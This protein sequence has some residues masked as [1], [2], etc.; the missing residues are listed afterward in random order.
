MWDVDDAVS[1]GACSDSPP[2]HVNCTEQHVHNSASAAAAASCWLPSNGESR[3]AHYVRSKFANEKTAS[4]KRVVCHNTCSEASDA[5]ASHV[6]ALPLA[7]TVAKQPSAAS[8]NCHSV[9]RTS[10]HLYSDH[11]VDDGYFLNN[12]HRNVAPASDIDTGCASESVRSEYF[13]TNGVDLRSSLLQTSVNETVHSVDHVNHHS[14]CP[15]HDDRLSSSDWTVVVGGEANSSSATNT[16]LTETLTSVLANADLCDDDGYM[17]EIDVA[18]MTAVEHRHGPCAPWLVETDACLDD[19]IDA[20]M[21]H[22]AAVAGSPS[23]SSL[24]STHDESTRIP[25]DDSRGTD[26]AVNASESDVLVGRHRHLPE[27]F[28][29]SS[30]SEEQQTEGSSCPGIGNSVWADNRN[31]GCTFVSEMQPSH[32]GRCLESETAMAR[33]C[34]GV[35]MQVQRSNPASESSHDTPPAS[36]PSPSDYYY[37]NA[38]MMGAAFLIPVTDEEVFEDGHSAGL[39]TGARKHSETRDGLRGPKQNQCYWLPFGPESHQ[40]KFS[41]RSCLGGMNNVSLSLLAGYVTAGRSRLCDSRDSSVM[42]RSATGDYVSYDQSPDLLTD[43]CETSAAS[44][45]SSRM[46]S[47]LT[48]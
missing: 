47:S 25:E 19:F 35:N 9:A 48:L 28:R 39:S 22:N 33:S 30:N 23:S 43:D 18:A 32:S 21:P 6:D 8:V 14:A 10:R 15:V 13:S 12:T 44:V 31:A 20:D 24:S 27:N 38:E 36:L 4:L 5:S 42:W 3:P 11:V 29:R 45:L 41:C 26:I 1:N 2:S 7:D 34:H 46:S 40:P 37:G 17:D 16:D